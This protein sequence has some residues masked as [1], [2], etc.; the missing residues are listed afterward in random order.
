[1]TMTGG[2]RSVA[3]WKKKKPFRA[4]EAAKGAIE[5]A[6]TLSIIW[7]DSPLEETGRRRDAGFCRAAAA[8]VRAFWRVRAPEGSGPHLL[9]I[10][11]VAAPRTGKRRHCDQQRPRHELSHA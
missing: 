4:C 8:R 1:F 3:Q 5:Y 10:I 6:P 11:C 7:C 2:T 9:R